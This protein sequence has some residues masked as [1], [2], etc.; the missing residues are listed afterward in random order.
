MRM[1]LGLDIFLEKHTKKIKNKKIGLITNLTGVN[2]ELDST[3]DLLYK[4]ENIDLVALYGPE[5]GIRGV[6]KAG[7]K[8]DFFVDELT[9]L[10]VFSLYGKTRMP[11]QN[12]MKNIDL[13]IFDLQDIGS[14]YYTYIYTL[15]YVMKACEK[16]GKELIVLDRPNPITGVI[17]EGNLVEKEYSSFVGMYPIPNR[18]GLTIG[19]LSLLY[20][21]EYNLNCK[22]K[23]I[24]MEGWKREL[25]YD[26]TE[27]IWIPP[28]P[29]TTSIDMTILYAGT[30]LF[31][32]TNLS[33]GRGTAYPFEVIGAPFINGNE[34]A[35]RF[36]NENLPGIIARPTSFKPTY[37]KYKD[38]L[39]S[40]IHLHITNRNKF[41]PV[42]SAITL[43]S[44]VQKLYPKQFKFHSVA[45]G[46]R[47]FFDLLAGTDKLRHQILAGNTDSYFI[48]SEKQLESFTEISKEYRLY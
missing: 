35:Q 47:L 19:E 8:V 3:I 12:M 23:V 43:L 42:K 37:Q 16:Y 9:G 7:E 31:E 15:A 5:H 45:N 11:T 21:Y 30:C 25:Y 40:G 27:F 20:K 2:K 34:L 44:I 28:S 39:C 46:E 29:N 18:H 33:E 32:G 17:S 41:M 38:E 36:N 26:E 22:L 14:R 13:M 24:P 4:H 6:A 10:P 48:E 1:K